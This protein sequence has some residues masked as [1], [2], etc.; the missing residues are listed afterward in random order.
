MA[1]VVAVA[2]PDVS[3]LQRVEQ[4]DGGDDDGDGDGYLPVGAD[5]DQDV[6]CR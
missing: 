2:E 4:G 1:D 5:S 3:D 6:Q